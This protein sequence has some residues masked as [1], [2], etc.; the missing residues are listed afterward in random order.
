MNL[1]CAF[2]GGTHDI[3]DAAWHF[4]E[5]VQWLLASE[6]ERERSAITEDQCQLVTHEGMHFF[7]RALLNLPIKGSD[8][9]FTWGVWCSLSEKSY[10]EV[11]DNWENPDRTSLGPYFGWLCSSI[12][13][14]PD[15]V[16]LKTILHQREVG[17]R[18]KVEL[19]PTTHPLAVHQ[20]EGID[21]AELHR[22]VSTL[23][24]KHEKQNED[25]PAAATSAGIANGAGSA[26]SP[27]SVRPL[28]SVAFVVFVFAHFLPALGEYSGFVCDY[29]SWVMLFTNPIRGF[30]TAAFALDN[31]LLVVLFA[32]AQTR[33]RF[34]GWTVILSGLSLLHVLSWWGLA[35]DKGNATITRSGIG[36]GY[37]LWAAAFV[38]IFFM[39]LQR[40]QRDRGLR[41]E[42]EAH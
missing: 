28:A 25:Q 16:Y 13:G 11:S 38:L 34:G 9:V 27:S 15:T 10:A 5:P 12:P 17:L 41:D 29:V 7:I 19:E 39:A 6:V 3:L 4:R 23:F 22:M 32:R 24:H 42:K 14:Y 33:L 20:R 26:Q 35:G 2:C 36:I 8:Q 37:Y 30:Y 31:L 21:P 1:Q 40:W 18:P